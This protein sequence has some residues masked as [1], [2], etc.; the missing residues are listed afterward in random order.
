MFV[1][2]SNGGQRGVIR[3]ERRHTLDIDHV[4]A[5]DGGVEADVCLCDLVAEVVGAGG[6]GEV[7]LDAVEV[8]EEGNDGFF[9]G[10]L[11]AFGC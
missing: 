3:G 10:G 2:K 11:G 5:D 9:V 6:G 1:L 4:E 8:L 7:L